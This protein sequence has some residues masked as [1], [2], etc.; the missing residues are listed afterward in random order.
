MFEE[1]YDLNLQ[2]SSGSGT[3]GQSMGTLGMYAML[4]HGATANIREMQTWKSEGRDPLDN[5]PFHF[6]YCLGGTSG[7]ATILMSRHPYSSFL[8]KTNQPGA[9]PGHWATKN[10]GPKMRPL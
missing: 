3:G 6:L 9:I 2:P 1:H 5:F 7:R 8:P 4:A 10:G